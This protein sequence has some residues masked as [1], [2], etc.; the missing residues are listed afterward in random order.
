MSFDVFDYKKK[1]QG[2]QRKDKKIRTEHER[3]RER[4]VHCSC[5]RFGLLCSSRKNNEK[6]KKNL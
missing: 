3:E 2:R 6:L 4:K 1:V 5:S